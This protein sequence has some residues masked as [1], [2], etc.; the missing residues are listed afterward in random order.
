M[1]PR[2]EC[3]EMKVKCITNR[4]IVRETNEDAGGTFY[5][6]NNQLLAIVADGMG[7][8][9]AGEIASKLAVV[10]AKDSWENQS[11]LM[12]A[13]EAEQYLKQLMIEMNEIVL[14][15]SKENPQY[16]GMGTTVVLAICTDQFAT[17]GHIGDSRCYVWNTE[18]LKQL[19]EDH[20]YVNELVRSGEISA[21]EAATHP[22]KNVLLHV[23]GTDEHVNAEIITIGFEKD[24]VLL[25]CSDG[26]YNKITETEM[27]DAIANDC[28]F[29]EK[30]DPL[31]LLA[32]E[33]GGEDNITLVAILHD[34]EEKD[35]DTS[36]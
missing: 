16:E 33:R 25:L 8:H 18:G 26:L 11:T 5:N 20:S 29:V 19:T 2:M 6:L 12:T 30:W 31:V 27:A 7:G 22:K 15:Q 34:E 35:G 4:G 24:N 10:H 13:T 36:C 17:I 21:D 9:Q 23:I 28:P 1:D 32:N 3:D 14:K